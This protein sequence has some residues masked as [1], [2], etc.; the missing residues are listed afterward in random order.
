MGNSVLLTEGL[1]PFHDGVSSTIGTNLAIEINKK[2]G[3]LAF[4]SGPFG[5]VKGWVNEHG[6]HHV[7]SKIADSGAFVHPTYRNPQA[8]PGLVTPIRNESFAYL[9]AEAAGWV[10]RYTDCL[11]SV[12]VKFGQVFIIRPKNWSKSLTS[13]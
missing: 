12:V 5:S 3:Y 11:Y 4:I 7:Q 2:V 10:N 8:G 1:D 9:M 13:K 6:Y